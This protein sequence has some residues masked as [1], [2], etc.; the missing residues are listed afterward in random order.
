MWSIYCSLL[1]F[2]NAQATYTL[3]AKSDD[4]LFIFWNTHIHT[5]TH[6]YTQSLSAD[7][8]QRQANRPAVCHSGQSVPLPSANPVALWDIWAGRGESRK[9]KGGRGGGRRWW[10]WEKCTWHTDESQRD[11]L[12]QKTSQSLYQL[13]LDSVSCLLPSL[14]LSLPL[15]TYPLTSIAQV[16]SLCSVCLCQF[17][18]LYDKDRTVTIHYDSRL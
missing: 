14:S 9:G 6:T 2:R 17:K 4:V 11:R 18:I 13:S 5:N 8:G 16:L 1:G 10:L 3:N 12:W 15:F 7:T